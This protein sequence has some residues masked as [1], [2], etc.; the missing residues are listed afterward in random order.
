MGGYN[1][2]KEENTPEDVTPGLDPVVEHYG[3]LAVTRPSIA[4]RGVFTSHAS[5]G[6]KI[7]ET[8]DVR[9]KEAEAESTVGEEVVLIWRVVKLSGR[10]IRE[11]VVLKVTSN[12]PRGVWVLKCNAKA[13]KRR[14]HVEIPIANFPLRLRRPQF[15]TP[16]RDT[17]PHLSQWYGSS[18]RTTS[19]PADSLS[20]RLPKS[21]PPSSGA[22]TRMISESSS[23]S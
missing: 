16:T 5:I 17:P 6:D 12:F 22:R 13:H 2:K 10:H 7:S 1:D 15:P 20:R 4:D 9:S 11:G 3:Q 23:T 18:K 14:S 8:H 21:R 19:T